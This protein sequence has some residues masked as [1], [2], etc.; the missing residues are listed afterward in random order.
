[1]A[2]TT[3]LGDTP[4]S[5]AAKACLTSA[6]TDCAGKVTA[7]AH[8]SQ[9]IGPYGLAMWGPGSLAAKACL[10]SAKT[11]CAG[12]VTANAQLMRIGPY[13]LAMWGTALSKS[14]TSM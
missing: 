11:D 10:T 9:R 7:N 2:I 8:D 12:K 6:K 13:G 14:Y 1:M 4:G 5:L 3:A